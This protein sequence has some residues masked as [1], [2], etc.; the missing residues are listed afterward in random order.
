MNCR[1]DTH[2]DFVGVVPGN[3]LVHIE[4][5]AVL[6]GNLGLTHALDGFFEV[7][8]HA[9]GYAT[10]FGTYAATLV[11][12][13]L[14]L[15]RSDIARYQVTEGGVDALQVVVAIFFGNISR[16]LLAVLG[17]LRHPDTTVVTQRL[18]HQSQLGL[19][20]A[21]L[22]NTG[23]VNLGVAG[24]TEVGPVLVGLPRSR[25]ITAHGVSGEE[26]DVA[27]TSRSQNH[28]VSQPGLDLAVRQIAGHDAAGTSVLDD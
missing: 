11:T 7:Q 28:G 24:V 8:V 19:E 20:G 12:H 4:E 1:I 2:R 18:G 23:R 21:V 25:D 13:I 9:A 6:G 10:N 3:A 16:I 26:E 14:G 27:V 22:G 5:V 17:L 15:A